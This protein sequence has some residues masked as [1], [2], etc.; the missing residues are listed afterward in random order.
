M[1]VYNFF[2]D[3]FWE[4]LINFHNRNKPEITTNT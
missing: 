2:K 3:C 1:H 4:I